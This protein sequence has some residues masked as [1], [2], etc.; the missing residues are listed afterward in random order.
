M[1][2]ELRDPFEPFVA[3]PFRALFP[4][5][6]ARDPFIPLA[7]DPF[8]QTQPGRVSRNTQAL[9]TRGLISRAAEEAIDRNERLVVLPSV[10]AHRELGMIQRPL[11]TPFLQ[12]ASSMMQTASRSDP[13]ACREGEMRSSE[14]RWTIPWI[15]PVCTLGNDSPLGRCGACNQTRPSSGTDTSIDIRGDDGRDDARRKAAAESESDCVVCMDCTRDV[16]LVHG[17]DGHHVCCRDCAERLHEEGNA[18]C[19]VCL[20]PIEAVLNYFS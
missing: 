14:G 3:D 11:P 20:R 7:F 18:R 1:A 9:T 15:C 5:S 8:M 16:I 2:E 6:Q 19:P 4:Q 10:L 12:Q 13:P 17:Q